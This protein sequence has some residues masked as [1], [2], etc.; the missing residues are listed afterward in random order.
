MD[1]EEL[2]QNGFQLFYKASDGWGVNY[3]EIKEAD[4]QKFIEE[5]K[6]LQAA[7]SGSLPL[8]KIFKFISAVGYNYDYQLQGKW[9]R[10][11]WD[12]M[13]LVDVRHYSIEEI[14]ERYVSEGG[15]DR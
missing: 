10:K 8:D 4:L 14:Y 1:K 12:D 6:S 7:V 2:K 11:E 15:N 5:I 13:P 9:Q 3:Y